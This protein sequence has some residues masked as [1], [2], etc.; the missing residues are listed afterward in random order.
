MRSRW[1][2]L[3]RQQT[4]CECRGLLDDEAVVHQVERLPWD[5]G[6]FALPTHEV[7]V[8]GVEERERFRQGV[9]QDG[10]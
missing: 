10:R 2:L 4:P 9:A 3:P 1:L 8:G 5:V 6:L 7:R